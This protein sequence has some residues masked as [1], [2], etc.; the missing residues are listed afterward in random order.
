[1]KTFADRLKALRKKSK[2]SV[3]ALAEKCGLSRQT[4]HNLE[5]GTHRPAWDV[6]QSLATALGV[7]TDVFR[8]K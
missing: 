7:S 6:V 8:D 2:L 3:A 4:I 5:A 1:M